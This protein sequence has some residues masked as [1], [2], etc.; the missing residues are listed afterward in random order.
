M[1]SGEGQAESLADLQHMRLL[2]G[3]DATHSLPSGHCRGVLTN[4]ASHGP[5]A[6]EQCKN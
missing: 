4:S 2:F 3:G 6:A 1:L 5:D